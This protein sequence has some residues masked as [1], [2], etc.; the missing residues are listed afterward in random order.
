[1]AIIVAHQHC[2]D[3][4]TIWSD[5]QAAVKLWRRCLKP[6]AKRYVGAL[7]EM[8]PFLQAAKRRLPGVQVVWIPSHLSVEEFV[9]AGMPQHAWAGNDAADVAGKQRAG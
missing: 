4:A 3:K 6:G 7:Q 1:M 2:E 9:G 5:C 8:L